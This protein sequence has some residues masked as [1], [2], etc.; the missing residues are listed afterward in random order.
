MSEGVFVCECVCVNLC[1]CVS[2]SECECGG[3]CIGQTNLFKDAMVLEV[4]SVMV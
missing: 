2:V 3:Y 4:A 1:V